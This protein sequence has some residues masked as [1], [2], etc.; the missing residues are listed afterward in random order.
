[1]KTYGNTKRI[2]SNHPDY[3]PPKGWKNWWDEDF[4]SK[5]SERFNSKLEIEEKVYEYFSEQENLG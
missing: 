4:I 2:I 1:M 3:H 5:T